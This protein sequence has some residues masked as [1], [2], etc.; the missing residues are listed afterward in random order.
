[1]RFVAELFCPWVCWCDVAVK[2]GAEASH[3][4]LVAPFSGGTLTSAAKYCTARFGKVKY[5]LEPVTKKE[6]KKNVLHYT[7]LTTEEKGYGDES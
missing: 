5:F 2:E 1:M 6:L 7:F 4:T 3:E